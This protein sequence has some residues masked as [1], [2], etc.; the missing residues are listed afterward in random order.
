[1]DLKKISLTKVYDDGLIVDEWFYLAE[2]EVEKSA[3][4]IRLLINRYF[5]SSD[6]RGYT[7]SDINLSPKNG[8][9]FS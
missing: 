4:I 1:M 6:G 5:R 3:P 2:E 7:I 9:I 8:R